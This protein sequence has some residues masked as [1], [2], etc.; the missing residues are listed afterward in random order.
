M[1]IHTKDGKTAVPPKIVVRPAA[2][3]DVPALACLLRDLCHQQ[4]DD[5]IDVDE[6]RFAAHLFGPSPAGTAFAA[7]R[8]R[9]ALVGFAVCET[10]FNGART[11]GGLY[12][13]ELYVAPDHRRQG[14]GRRLLAA[15]ARLAQARGL[16]YVEWVSHARNADAQAMY[17]RLGAAAHPLVGHVLK[18]ATFE[19]LVRE[20]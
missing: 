2:T 18:G 1:A 7:D 8:G 13:A 17:A 9:G 15:V 10:S 5:P 14:I 3:G 20:G 19:R 11:Q 6:S 4:G 12:L 16:A